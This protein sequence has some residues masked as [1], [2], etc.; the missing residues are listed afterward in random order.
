MLIARDEFYPDL[1]VLDCCLLDIPWGFA[2]TIDI[3]LP[4]TFRFG[5]DWA[6]LF[7]E[8]VEVILV[9]PLAVLGSGGS[10]RLLLRGGMLAVWGSGSTISGSD[11]N[12]GSPGDIS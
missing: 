12:G 10:S 9:G 2:E 8:S 3:G 6:I 5:R 11:N 7:S 4:A 1:I